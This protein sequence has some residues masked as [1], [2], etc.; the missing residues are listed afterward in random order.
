[1]ANTVDSSWLLRPVMRLSDAFLK[2]AEQDKRW[3]NNP[4]PEPLGEDVTR[5]HGN[6]RDADRHAHL[7]ARLRKQRAAREWRGTSR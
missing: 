3:G 2:P 6:A 5:E 4:T 1:M 7:H